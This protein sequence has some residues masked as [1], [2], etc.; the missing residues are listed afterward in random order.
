MRAKPIS[1]AQVLKTKGKTKDCEVRPQRTLFEMM[2][3][4]QIAPNEDFTLYL[5]QTSLHQTNRVNSFRAM[6]SKISNAQEEIFDSWIQKQSF[7]SN[8]ENHIKQLI[9]SKNTQ[10]ESQR[11]FKEAKKIALSS[12][13]KENREPLRSVA[14]LIRKIELTESNTNVPFFKANGKSLA[15][16][17][18]LA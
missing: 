17:E 16:N 18:K 9:T 2:E 3:E 13:S 14:D 12:K 15:T 11:D 1:F 6:S 7:V 10:G 4:F 5:G 8:K